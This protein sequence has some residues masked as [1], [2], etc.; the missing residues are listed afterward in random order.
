MSL[1]VSL[2]FP[3]SVIKKGIGGG[4]IKLYSLVGGHEVQKEMTS[5]AAIASLPINRNT[6]A[7]YSAEYARGETRAI[8]S[9]N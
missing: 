8:T 7:S 3:V 9:K 2:S 1:N 5:Y 4:G 6:F